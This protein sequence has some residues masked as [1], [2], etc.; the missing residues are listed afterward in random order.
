MKLKEISEDLKLGREA[1]DD[2]KEVEILQDWQW[3]RKL[4][5]WYLK[6]SI[7]TEINREIPADSI[8]YVV[9]DN[10]YPKK[11]V[12]IYPDAHKGCILTFEHQSNNGIIGENGLWRKGSPCLDS[13]LRALERYDTDPEPFDAFSRLYWHI[14]RL[15]LWI[16]AVN[17]KTLVKTG[18]PFELPQFNETIKHDDTYHYFVFSE[19]DD[20]F[21]QWNNARNNSG[22]A[23]LYEYESDKNE[24]KDVYFIVKEFRSV[25]DVNWGTYL[26]LNF[27]N[28]VTAIWIM[29]NEVP[30]VNYWQAPNFFKELNDACEAQG[31]NLRKIIANIVNKNSNILRDNAKHL[32]FLGFPIPEKIEGKNSIIHWQALKLPPFFKEIKKINGFRN[33]KILLSKWDEHRVL[34]D[35]LELEWLNSQNWSIQ[36]ITNRGRLPKDIISKK[37]LIIGAG[38]IG[39]SLAEL[40]VRSGL[41]NISLMDYDILEIG[42]LSRYPLGLKEI[43]KPKSYETAFHLIPIN[44][45]V[46][47]KAHFKKFEYSQDIFEELSKFDLIVDCTGEDSVLYDLEKFEFKK[48]KI[49]V[50]ISIGIAAEKLYLSM[51]KGKKFKSDDFFEMISP[52]IEKDIDKFPEYDLPRDGAN[53]W[54]PVFPARYDDILLAT[55]TAVK[56]IE[57]FIKKDKT[58]SNNIYKKYSNEFIGYI[59]VE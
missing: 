43:G 7:I 59:K 17:T 58:E 16:H 48:D 51:Q 54:N 27:N 30:V 22:I 26:S 36:K 3:D 15:I 45:H 33:P 2:I 46:N 24:F 29:L 31:I 6:I 37:T 57:D 53:C 41:T 32:L 35:E 20:S 1:I 23:E 10:D 34:K 52:W 42:N 19:D 38:T 39:T 11:A 28:P 5:K 49:F 13:Q 40:F 18:E 9:V 4:N 25:Y 55:S 12:K 44:P 50:S 56:I 47:A 21:K 8:W 14:K